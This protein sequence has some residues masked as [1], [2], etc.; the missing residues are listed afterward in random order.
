MRKRYDYSIARNLTIIT[1]VL[2]GSQFF[3]EISG[4]MSRKPE[5]YWIIDVCGGLFFMSVIY[6]FVLI[7]LNSRQG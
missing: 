1:G 3:I 5:F 4:I 6:S 2:F 7:L